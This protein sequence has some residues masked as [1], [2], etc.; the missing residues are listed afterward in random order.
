MSYSIPIPYI[1]ALESQDLGHPKTAKGYI[2]SQGLTYSFHHDA[3][4]LIKLPH[5]LIRSHKE[6]NQIFLNKQ[7]CLTSEILHQHFSVFH[8]FRKYWK[9]KD[10][11]NKAQLWGFILKES[12]N[13]EIKKTILCIW[14]PI[15]LLNGIHHS[16]GIILAYHVSNLYCSNVLLWNTV[17]YC[18]CTVAHASRIFQEKKGRGLL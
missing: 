5:L 15:G 4:S 2:Y 11:V 18:M 14:S 6:S 13:G 8:F 17:T 9:M 12:F 3:R 16:S 7:S 1:H 10:R